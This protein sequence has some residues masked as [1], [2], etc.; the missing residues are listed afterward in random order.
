[1][2]VYLDSRDPSM[3]INYSEFVPIECGGSPF[4]G[5]VAIL[6]ALGNSVKDIENQIDLLQYFNDNEDGSRL[7]SLVLF[8]RRFGCNL[9]VNLV[10]PEEQDEWHLFRVSGSMRTIT[11]KIISY[12]GEELNL[13]AHAQ[14]MGLRGVYNESS[15]IDY[16]NVW[17]DVFKTSNILKVFTCVTSLIGCGYLFSRRLSLK[18]AGDSFRMA[19]SNTFYPYLA[20]GA[21]SWGM[22]WFGLNFKYCPNYYKFEHR[23]QAHDM[24][25]VRNF[26][27]KRDKIEVHDLI[28][29]F[30]KSTALGLFFRDK[31]IISIKTPC[32]KRIS[33]SVETSKLWVNEVR[34]LVASGKKAD[35]S[36]F[37]LRRNTGINISP[38]LNN[39]ID[40]LEF[41][42][43]TTSPSPRETI[44]RPLL[45]YVEPGCNSMLPDPE[46]VIGS[47][48]NKI[49]RYRHQTTKVK[50]A[51]ICDI[52]VYTDAGLLGAGRYSCSDPETVLVAFAGRS[53]KKR[54]INQDRVKEF[55]EFSFS[56]VDRLV[57]EFD[58]T[59]LSSELSPDHA[60]S[61]IMH[62]KKSR[63]YINQQIEGWKRALLGD[64]KEKQ[65]SCFVKFESNDKNGMAKPRL[66][67]TMS[68]YLS[69][70]AVQVLPV[71]DKIIETTSFNKTAIKHKSFDEIMEQLV[72]VC[73]GKHMVTDYSSWESSL[74]PIIRKIEN[75][76]LVKCLEKTGYSRTLS[77]LRSE[78]FGVDKGRKLHYKGSVY[79]IQTRCSGDYWTSF[80]NGLINYCLSRF[81][82]RANPHFIGVF[83][84]DDGVIK[85][86]SSSMTEDAK[87]LGFDLGTSVSGTQMGDVDFLQVRY[88]IDGKRY[89]NVG[90]FFR[91][92]WLRKAHNLK[93]SKRGYLYQCIAASLHHLSP[94]HPVIFELANLCY[95]TGVVLGGKKFVG[96]K[97]YLNDYKDLNY[98]FAS[99]KWP[100]NADE[101]MR[102]EVAQGAQGFPSIEVGRQLW[103]EA[104]LRK[105]WLGGESVYIGSSMNHCDKVV[106]YLNSNDLLVE[107]D[108]KIQRFRNFLVESRILADVSLV[109]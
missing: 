98:D 88:G 68:S 24:R 31:E 40:T 39:D 60:Y 28:D 91:S 1:M 102:L 75:R 107:P 29:V 27:A 61:L 65:H 16:S 108:R 62:G 8:A 11:L 82:V 21:I 50:V 32:V 96:F 76:M 14:L 17:T 42:A 46:L 58:P 34:N 83:E 22:N 94:G 26:V 70:E 43:N 6:R 20:L 9:R 69:V 57:S 47:D 3:P 5:Q 7:E 2:L 80:G 64:K 44:V 79:K 10:G 77:T 49:I 109:L 59:G 53:M 66:I 56:I 33:V 95:F 84:G 23:I 48:Y 81:L 100:L 52:P 51:A 15:L 35:L 103:L 101:N 105:A 18:S 97:R 90:K 92:V 36:V 71:I 38:F 54:D 99:V 41:L 19:L 89:L 73:D 30:T 25:D 85:N 55:L 86:P 104:Q 13:L 45:A 106:E 74:T 37:G 67:M 87:E 72:E 93:D 4:C 63:S 78:L 12:Y